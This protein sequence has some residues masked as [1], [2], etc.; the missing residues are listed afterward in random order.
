MFIVAKEFKLEN[1][2]TQHLTLQANGE[3]YRIATESDFNPKGYRTVR[4][5]KRKAADMGSTWKVYEYGVC[6]EE[7]N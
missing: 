5:A 3:D 6:F 7:V 1:G 4:G 2:M